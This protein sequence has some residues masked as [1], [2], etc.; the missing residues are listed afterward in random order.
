[1][2]QESIYWLQTIAVGPLTRDVRH[3]NMIKI[4]VLIFLFVWHSFSQPIV[5]KHF[6]DSAASSIE[7]GAFYVNVDSLIHSNFN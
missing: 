1:V 3:I 5:K 6:T 4:Y 2:V 7:Y